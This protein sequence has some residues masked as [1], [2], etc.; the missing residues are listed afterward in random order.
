MPKNRYESDTFRRWNQNI[1][2]LTPSNYT[3]RIELALEIRALANRMK[4]PKVLELG[5]GEGDLTKYILEANLHMH[6]DALD[7]SEQMIHSARKHLHTYSNRVNFI[8]DDVL[9]YL[10]DT[11]K[12]YNVIVS[13]WVVHNFT[14]EEKLAVFNAI[15]HNLLGG[16]YLLLMEKIYPDSA[17]ERRKLLNL[18]LKRYSYLDNKEA[19]DEICAH[20]KADFG[21]KYV[22][23]ESQTIESFSKLG[24]RDIK[25]K[26]RIERD[27]LIISRK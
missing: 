24:F 25:I 11:K 14:W 12:H 23:G 9:H 16:G 18:Q 4:D 20:E 17:A 10:R 2:S 7:I 27:I 3:M 26:D 19:R 13:S 6:I 15:Y 5:V 21:S 1:I 8:C 22:M